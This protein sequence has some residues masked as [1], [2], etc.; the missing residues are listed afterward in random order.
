MEIVE[1]EDA[2]RDDFSGPEAVAKEGT[3]ESGNVRMSVGCQ[4]QGIELEFFVFNM[5][6]TIGGEGLSVAGTA[7]GVHAVEHVDP[8]GDHF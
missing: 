6:R 7:G 5:D 4:G 1:G 2:L 8:L 3:G